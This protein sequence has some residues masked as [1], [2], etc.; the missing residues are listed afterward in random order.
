VPEMVV[1]EIK[2]AVK[3]LG[4]IIGEVTSEDVLDQIF[5][6]FCIGK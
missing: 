1:F 5:S 2:E 6:T 4:E 3:T